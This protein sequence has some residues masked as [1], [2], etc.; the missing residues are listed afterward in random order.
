MRDMFVQRIEPRGRGFTSFHCY[1]YYCNRVHCVC[2]GPWFFN[3][4]FPVV[5]SLFDWVG[6]LWPQLSKVLKLVRAGPAA[7]SF[8]QCP[9]RS[10]SPFSVSRYLGTNASDSEESLHCFLVGVNKS[11][12]TATSDLWLFS[13]AFNLLPSLPT[14]LPY[15]MFKATPQMVCISEDLE[16]LGAW[17][18]S[19]KRKAKDMTPSI[20]S[21]AW[22][23]EVLDDLLIIFYGFLR[24]F[25]VK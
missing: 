13:H 12:V 23:E 8:P 1:Y 2:P 16:C 14:P 15:T 5:L 18:T 21:M 10:R 20:A 3:L 17:D 7:S 24:S 9:C 22:K 11:Y 4:F 25:P 19:R 6:I